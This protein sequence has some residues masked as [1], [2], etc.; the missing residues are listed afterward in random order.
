MK[1]YFLS[2]IFMIILFSIKDVQAFGIGTANN[3]VYVGQTIGVTVD[4]SDLT[5]KFT[6]SS[7]NQ[8]VLRGGNSDWYENQ[9]TVIYFDAVGTGQATITAYSN[10][11]SNKNGD[12]QGEVSRSITINVIERPTYTPIEINRT[13]SDNN[14][15]SSLAI[16]GYEIKPEFDKEVLEYNLEL[17]YTIEKINISANPEDERTTINGLGE[18]EVNEGNN[19]IKITAVAENGNERVY[20]INV[21]VKEIDPIEVKIGDDKYTLLKKESLLPEVDDFDKKNIKIDKKDIPALYNAKTKY[22]LVGLKD[23]KGKIEL[24]IYNEKDKSYT[25]YN[26]VSFNGLR[27]NFLENNNN[28]NYKEVTI[29]I[30]GQ[31]VNAYKKKGLDYYL[32]Y[33]MNIKT[34]KKNWYTYDK[35]EKTLQRYID[36]SDI[37][38]DTL[39]NLVI[40]L[41]SISGVLMFFLFV[42]SIKYKTK[43]I[44]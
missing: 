19:E 31:H 39:N 17:D 3:T 23:S 10:N 25:K 42:L 2:I 5:G 20:T 21:L 33:G 29:K 27:V 32:V 34:G 9:S 36:S 15:I 37:S 40:L 22:T 35:E 26:E 18:K 38:S 6:I 13:Y 44:S 7:S 11:P 41:G 1:K 43:K 24:Y 8:S 4:M 12:N 14:Y 28:N 16:D 30:N